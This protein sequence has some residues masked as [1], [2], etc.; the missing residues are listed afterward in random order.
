MEDVY[1]NVEEYNL[2]RKHEVLFDDIIAD[3]ISNEKLNQ[4][5]IEIFLTGKKLNTSTVFIT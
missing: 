4:V 3:M 2:D 1:K 5:V